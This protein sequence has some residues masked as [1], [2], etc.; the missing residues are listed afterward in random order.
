MGGRLETKDP[1]MRDQPEALDNMRRIIGLALLIG[2]FLGGYHLGRQKDSPD[3]IGYA[4]Q[5]VVAVAAVAGEIADSFSN[6]HADRADQA[7]PTSPS[8]TR[9]DDRAG[10]APDRDTRAYVNQYYTPQPSRDAPAEARQAPSAPADAQPVAQPA[11]QP[12]VDWAARIWQSLQQ[13]LQE[14]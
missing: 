5:A 4:R 8:V 11:R 7:D 12:G 1:A 13:P 3:V 2:A 10:V 14:K 6:K 9:A